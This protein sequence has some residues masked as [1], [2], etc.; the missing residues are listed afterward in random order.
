MSMQKRNLRQ[1][2]THWTATPDGFGGYN[3]TT[4]VIMSCRWERKNK[5][6]RDSQGEELTSIALVYLSS[7]VEIGDY[8][9]E[10]ESN[11][12]DPTTLTE[13][14]RVRQFNRLTD[15]RNIDIQRLAFL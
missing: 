5:V 13:A 14:R 1:K 4:P 3:Y 11:A 6:F 9:F 7:D 10:G 15:L 12:A 2:A 8:L